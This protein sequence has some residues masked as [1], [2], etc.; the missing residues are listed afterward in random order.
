MRASGKAAAQKLTTHQ[1]QI[2]ERLILAHGDDTEVSLP[3]PPPHGSVTEIPA[4]MFPAWLRGVG[5][6]PAFPWVG[7][8][9]V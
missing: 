6:R 1:L 3:L 9:G 5:Q 8:Y 7:Y 2:M 4:R